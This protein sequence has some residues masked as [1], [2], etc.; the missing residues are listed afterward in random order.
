[1]EEEEKMVT[2]NVLM[3]RSRSCERWDD[4]LL[5]FELECR[6]LSAH[7]IHYFSDDKI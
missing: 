3:I 5:L 4:F 2:G 1:M 6:A 7:W